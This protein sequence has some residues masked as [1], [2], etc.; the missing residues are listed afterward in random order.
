MRYL[1]IT[2]ISQTRV[3]YSQT[4]SNSSDKKP[5]SSDRNFLLVKNK[6]L[7]IIWIWKDTRHFVSKINLISTAVEKLWTSRNVRIVKNKNSITP[8]KMIG[9]NKLVL[10]RRKK[11][12]I[13][14]KYR[15]PAPLEFYNNI[16]SIEFTQN[17][18]LKFAWRLIEIINVSKIKPHF[19][20]VL[21][22]PCYL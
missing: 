21:S 2:V 13:F 4:K 10:D 19:S 11:F 7:N 14:L 5:E 15:K 3:R 9:Q 1:L 16:K 6:L 18:P 17:V 22:D 12:L 8:G 20:R